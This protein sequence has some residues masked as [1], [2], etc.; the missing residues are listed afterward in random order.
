MG[1]F[2][3]LLSSFPLLPTLLLSSPPFLSPPFPSPPFP[4]PHFPPLRLNPLFPGTNELDQIAR[5][6]NI[7][8]TPS[9]DVLDKFR[10]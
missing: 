3:C 10:R 6:H 8:G 2:F 1:A 7:L 5:I 4:S 9:D